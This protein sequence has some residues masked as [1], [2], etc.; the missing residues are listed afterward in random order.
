MDTCLG[1]HW[2]IQKV[3]LTDYQK[4]AYSKAIMVSW[5]RSSSLTVTLCRESVLLS[6]MEAH[7]L[8]MIMVSWNRSSSLT[9]TLCRESALLSEMDA[10]CLGMIMV[11]W[12]RSSSLTAT[13]C[14]E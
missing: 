12:N 1:Q 14:R 8:G 4:A 7:C 13:L 9:V 10:H 3:C 6:E 2:G 5:N 11:S